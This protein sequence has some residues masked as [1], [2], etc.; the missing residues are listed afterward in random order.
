MDGQTTGIQL[1][2]PASPEVLIPDAGLCPWLA[3]AAVAVLALVA[4]I[5]FLKK[6]RPVGRP[7][8]LRHTAFTDADRTLAATTTID[9]RD[10][11]VQS[12]LVLRH[13][14]AV[15][16][17]DPAL[18]ETH[19]QFISRHDALQALTAATRTAVQDGFNR[20]AA[21][22]YA[23]ELPAATAADVIAD[24]RALLATLNRGFAP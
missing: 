10:A 17:G 24:A 18:Y 6:Y 12:S 2:E 9:A 21:M 7:Q 11:A 14:L 16:A 1:M 8:S 5:I 20:L 22:K 3:T 15:A 19:E 4:M 23:P 13:Y